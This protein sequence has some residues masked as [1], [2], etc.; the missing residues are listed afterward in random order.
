MILAV[1]FQVANA[2]FANFDDDRCVVHNP[3]VC[4][5]FTADSLRWAFTT[6]YESNWTPLTWLSHMLCY[7]FLGPNAG[8]HHMLRLGQS[9]AHNNPGIALSGAGRNEEALEHLLEAVRIDPGNAKAHNNLAGVL[10]ALGRRDEAVNHY[11][12]VLDIDPANEQARENLRKLESPA[13]L[14]EP[15]RQP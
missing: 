8:A 2:Q 15:V 4:A 11:R 3:H 7:P 9:D 6:G 5:P 10:I 14:S 1:Y 13:G 12:K